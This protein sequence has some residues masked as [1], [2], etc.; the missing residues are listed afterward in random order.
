MMFEQKEIIEKLNKI[1]TIPHAFNFLQIWQKKLNAKNYNIDKEIYDNDN[2]N[3][4]L[5]QFANDFLSEIINP[6][7]R[8]FISEQTTRLL[9]NKETTQKLSLVNT[10]F[11]KVPDALWHNLSFESSKTFVDNQ[12]LPFLE[13]IQNIEQKDPQIATLKQCLTMITKENVNASIRT[14]MDFVEQK[15]ETFNKEEQTHININKALLLDNP[16]AHK[17]EI[18]A[19]ILHLF[20]LQYTKLTPYLTQAQKIELAYLEQVFYHFY[21]K[22]GILLIDND[23]K[24]AVKFNSLQDFAEHED[25]N[26]KS[27]HNHI[28]F[29]LN[30][31]QYDITIKIK[32]LFSLVYSFLNLCN[33][34][35]L[36]RQESE[37]IRSSQPIFK[38]FNQNLIV[39]VGG[40]LVSNRKRITYKKKGESHNFSNMFTLTLKQT[41]SILKNCF[42]N[43]KGFIKSNFFSSEAKVKNFIKYC[44]TTETK[45]LAG[46][47]NWRNE[48]Y[49]QEEENKKSRRHYFNVLSFNL[50]LSYLTDKVNNIKQAFDK[51]QTENNKSKRVA[52]LTKSLLERPL[53]KMDISNKEKDKKPI[54]PTEPK[55]K[56]ISV[57]ETVKRFENE[58]T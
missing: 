33:E 13:T 45:K 11:A 41:Q 23:K 47:D 44:L 57:K 20:I 19:N 6:D 9:K 16:F 56:E 52:L 7:H 32:R 12:T 18:I 10:D 24:N 35:V 31:G 50:D 36:D 2:F 22:D 46:T 38:N 51:T 58:V 43:D 21:D 49:K 27:L 4:V 55:N 34:E 42:V 54:L 30:Y 3:F 25:E 40:I 1:A 28:K 26:I 48:D 15:A 39:L 29:S 17:T 37:Q 8:D 14:F 5:E 53:L